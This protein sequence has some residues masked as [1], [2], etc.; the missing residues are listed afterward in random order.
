MSASAPAPAGPLAGRCHCGNLSYVLHTAKSWDD[1]V[2]RICRCDFCLRH[3]PRYWSDPEGRLEVEIAQPDRIVKY[4]FGH[5]TADFVFCT[6][7]GVYA[8]A[9]GSFDDGYR[10]VVNLNLALGRDRQPRETF[11]EALAESEAERT[12]RR[13][14]NWM[15]VTSGWPP[16]GE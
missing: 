11:I 16:A 4:R 12:A 14:R 5:G 15:P 2:V 6:G 8:F 13:A 3:R 10:A 9:V 1:V 7:C